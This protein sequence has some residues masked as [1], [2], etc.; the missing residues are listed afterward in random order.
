MELYATP[1]T[2]LYALAPI[3]AFLLTGQNPVSFYAGQGHSHRFC[4]QSVPGIPAA[5]ADVMQTLTNLRPADRYQSA[6]AVAM[7]LQAIRLSA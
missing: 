1:A 5:L 6:R 7:A 4:S 2:D 3:L